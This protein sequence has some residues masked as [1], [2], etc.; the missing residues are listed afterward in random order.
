MVDGVC[1]LP[2]PCV[3]SLVPSAGRRDA[4][5]AQIRPHPVG[6]SVL[7][8]NSNFKSVTPIRSAP[9]MAHGHPG[10]IGV[11][12]DKVVEGKKPN[13]FQFESELGFAAAQHPL[14]LHRGDHVLGPI[15]K[16]AHVNFYLSAPFPGTGDPGL[17]CQHVPHRVVS[18][19][20]SKGGSVTTQP[21][22]TEVPGVLGLPSRTLSATPRFL[23]QLMGYGQFG[24]RGVNVNGQTGISRVGNTLDSRR[25]SDGALVAS[26][27][28]NHAVGR[29]STFAPV[30]T[31]TTVGMAKGFGQSGIPGVCVTLPVVN[32]ALEGGLGPVN[33]YI[34]TTQWRGVSRKRFRFFSGGIPFTNVTS[35]R[36]SRMNVCPAGMFQH[37][38]E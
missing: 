36:A 13:L 34:L 14:T 19:K 2:G 38:T 6:V 9:H 8:P 11:R 5:A 15:Q 29:L 20:L 31:M 17:D 10:E 28:G 3:Q 7:D 24:P 26:T 23:V 16:P 37:A 27:M 32:R 21:Q 30:I 4:A 35:S 18:G 1:G 33:R 12:V 25:G 22:S